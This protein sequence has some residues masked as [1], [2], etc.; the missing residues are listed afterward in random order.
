VTEKSGSPAISRDVLGETIEGFR[1]L[2]EFL[3]L[4]DMRGSPP[5]MGMGT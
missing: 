3:G 4:G 2:R 5:K 1:R